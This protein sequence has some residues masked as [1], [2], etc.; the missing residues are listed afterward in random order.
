MCA[1]VVKIDW[2]N[3]PGP[4]SV[5][6]NYEYDMEAYEKQCADYKMWNEQY[7]KWKAKYEKL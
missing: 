5:K 6:F 1:N 7:Q 3:Q 4:W 2:E